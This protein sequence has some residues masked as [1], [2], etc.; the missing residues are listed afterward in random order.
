MIWMK[1]LARA[2][3]ASGGMVTGGNESGEEVG[4][5]GGGLTN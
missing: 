2:G 3:E 4:K 5:V 1:T